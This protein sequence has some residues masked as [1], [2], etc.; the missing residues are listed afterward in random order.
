MRIDIFRSELD[1]SNISQTQQ[2]AIGRAPDY[3]RP[4]IIDIAIGPGNADGEVEV[5]RFDP[6]SR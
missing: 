6:A 2:R 3:Q 1:A 4:E 5:R